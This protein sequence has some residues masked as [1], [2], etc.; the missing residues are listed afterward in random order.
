MKH[1]I[2]IV[3]TLCSFSV[4]GQSNLTGT[5]DTGEDNT[6]I[7]ITEIDGNP[8]G[9][10]K[11]SDNPNATISNVILKDVKKKG[12]IWKGKIYAAKR[13]EWYDAE[14][15]QKGNLLEIEINVGFLSKTVVWKK[16]DD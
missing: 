5:W 6:M 8:T 1:L 2:L 10:I 3:A 16:T 13:Q 15:T 11:S 4:F 14:I 12:E 7:E 9:K